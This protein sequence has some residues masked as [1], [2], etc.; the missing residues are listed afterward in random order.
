[1]ILAITALQVVLRNDQSSRIVQLGHIVLQV[2]GLQQ[3]VL[4]VLLTRFH[5]KTILLIAFHALLDSFAQ[6]QV[7]FSQQVFVMQA[8]TALEAT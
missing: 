7:W 6:Q 3:H 1:M 8:T 2:Q 5:I 4:L